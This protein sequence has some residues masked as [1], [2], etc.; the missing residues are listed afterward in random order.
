L[1]LAARRCEA[2]KK[3]TSGSFSELM[4]PSQVA[5]ARIAE[6]IALPV[7]LLYMTARPPEVQADWLAPYLVSAVIAVLGTWIVWRQKLVLNR[8]QLGLT[9]YFLTGAVALLVGWQ[10]L[11]SFYGRAEATAMLYWILVVGV[12][13]TAL[14]SSGFVGVAGIPRKTVVSASLGLLALL[15]AA[16]VLSWRFHTQPALAAYAPFLA[17]FAAHGIV[18]ARL[19]ALTTKAA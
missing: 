16:I 6:G 19:T 1:A 4:A 8:I 9:L 5:L 15:L 17:L 12:F 18:R 13:A 11:N 3:D 14:T 7:F 10:A 2:P